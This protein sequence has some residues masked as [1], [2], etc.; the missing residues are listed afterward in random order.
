MKS[1][2]KTISALAIVFSVNASASVMFDSGIPA[3]WDC[4]GNCGTL[5]A[6]GDVTA[7]PLGSSYGWVSTDGGVDGVGLDG[8][9]GEE[10]SIL[11][12]S[13]FAANANDPLEFYF[14]YVTSDGQGFAD[15]AWAALLD[16]SLNHVATLF[17]ARTLADGTIVPGSGM[18][19][20]EATLTPI[21]VPIIDKAPIWAPLGGNSGACYT[22]VGNG[23]GYTG[24]IQSSYN[25]AAAGNYYLTFGVTNW[26]DNGYD[27]GMAFDG[28]TVAGKAVGEVPEPTILSLFALAV[29]GFARR[30]SVK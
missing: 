4:T 20:P 2:L 11:R 10:G 9:V 23:C 12:S 7:S 16:E 30:K 6:D 8:L 27:S 26:D 22:G 1:L 18:P 14:N 21:N 24:W 5:G 29:L 17:T 19:T 28:I 3:G 15:Y 13:L 25:I